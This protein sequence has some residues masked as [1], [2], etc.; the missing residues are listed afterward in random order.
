MAEIT[1]P[2][3]PDPYLFDVGVTTLAHADTPVSDRPLSYV[4]KAIQGEIDAVVPYASLVGAHHVLV[5]TYGF[6][7]AE[8]TS[9]MRRFMDAKRIHWHDEIGESTVRAGFEL[10]GAV[11]V[12]GW[13]GYYA[14]V[15]RSEGVGT[16]LTLDDD[17]ERID[18]FE[19][20]VV[21]TSQEFERLNEY[22]ER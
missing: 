6:S 13:D 2:S 22:L 1:G 19:T 16:V 10:A 18:G 21:L 9:F 17:F 11:N 12:E 7:N 20:E 8:A 5:R 15:A 14:Q 4:R 3:G